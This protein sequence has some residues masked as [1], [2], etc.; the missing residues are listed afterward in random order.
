[1]PNLGSLLNLGMLA[2]SIIDYKQK[3]KFNEKISSKP[4]R[5]I[6]DWYCSAGAG[7]T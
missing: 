6:D 2:G 3:K 4:L 7:K 5:D 1:M